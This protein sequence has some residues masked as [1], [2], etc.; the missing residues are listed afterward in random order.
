MSDF[1]NKQSSFWGNTLK[2]ITGVVA[3]ATIVYV[4]D[5]NLSN[6]IAAEINTTNKLQLQIYCNDPNIDTAK[7]NNVDELVIS[8]PNAYKVYFNSMHS[9]IA[10][11]ISNFKTAETF[12]LQSY[13]YHYIDIALTQFI[14]KCTQRINRHAYGW[15]NYKI[16]LK[17]NLLNDITTIKEICMTLDDKIVLQRVL[18]T[19]LVNKCDAFIKLCK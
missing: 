2:I 3:T 19:Y 5:T 4:I 9:L 6:S 10:S 12:R 14:N 17:Q 7:S 8:D 13:Y 1:D 18:R 11:N 15:N 16:Q